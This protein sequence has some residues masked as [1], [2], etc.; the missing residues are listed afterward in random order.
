MYHYQPAAALEE[1][2]EDAALPNPVHVRDMMIRAHLSP[3]RAL[4]LNHKFQE[5]LHSFGEAE[6]LAR[7]I[8]EQLATEPLKRTHQ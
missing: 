7:A 1:L 2:Q 6:S 8:L 5:Y 4:E 3:E